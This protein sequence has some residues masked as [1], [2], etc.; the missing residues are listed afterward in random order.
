MNTSPRFGVVPKLSQH[1]ADVVIIKRFKSQSMLRHDKL[2]RSP[3]FFCH[4]SVLSA[5]GS[6]GSQTLDL[7]ITR[8]ML[9]HY[10]TAPGQKVVTQT[11]LNF[12]NLEVSLLNI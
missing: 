11:S 10:A 5:S 8:L 9:Y 3:L 2:E 12:K 1:A 6:A 4:F 7:G